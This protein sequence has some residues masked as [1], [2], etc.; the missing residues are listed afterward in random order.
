MA[1]HKAQK[2]RI[3]VADMSE[4]LS[5]K[6]FPLGTQIT[7][8]VKHVGVEQL[9]Y[10]EAYVLTIGDITME[11]LPVYNVVKKFVINGT[12][13][14]IIEKLHMGDLEGKQIRL[15]NVKYVTIGYNERYYDHEGF[16]IQPMHGFLME[17]DDWYIIKEGPD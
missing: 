15:V 12:N 7:G 1:V 16:L 17:G 11:T 2:D 9:Q 6:N 14:N 3:G 10:G 5:G 4:Y 13:R 8:T